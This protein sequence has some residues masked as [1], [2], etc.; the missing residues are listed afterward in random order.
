MRGSY[1]GTT[2]F[3]EDFHENSHCKPP[4]GFLA[5]LSFGCSS[6]KGLLDELS[7][8]PICHT[9]ELGGAI[10]ALGDVAFVRNE[11][12]ERGLDAVFSGDNRLV[13]FRQQPRQDGLLS[14]SPALWTTSSVS[15]LKST[16]TNLCHLFHT[17][18]QRKV[19][20]FRWFWFSRGFCPLTFLAL[21]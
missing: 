18:S 21:R 1:R 7:A 2:R 9:Y 15:V 19:F 8:Y 3:R 10:A 4:Q 20:L 17:E 13:L 16:R 11:I 6:R 5:F 12:T 14:P